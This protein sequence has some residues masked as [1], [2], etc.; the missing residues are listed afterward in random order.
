MKLALK[1][2]LIL[3]ISIVGIFAKEININKTLQEA[4]LQNKQIMLFFHIPRCPY[5]TSML[6]E[7]FNNK[8]ILDNISKNFILID[9]YTADK[10]IVIFND[11][12]GTPKEFAKLIGASAY[13]A[14]IF[15][16]RSS[17]VIYKSIGYRNIEEQLAEIK[18][19]ATNSYK[20]ID[21]ETFKI[22]LEIEDDE[23]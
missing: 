20:T 7:N 10:K 6:K 18:F 3:G 13:P 8:K 4:K 5:C 16:N 14:T 15:M 12:K 2:F 1:I 19:I 23:D 17:R 21:L 11:F 22:N 9:I